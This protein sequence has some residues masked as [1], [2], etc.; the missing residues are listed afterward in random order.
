MGNNKVSVCQLF[1]VRI[2]KLHLGC[3]VSVVYYVCVKEKKERERESER[4]MYVRT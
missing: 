1:I 3:E 2:R 4:V